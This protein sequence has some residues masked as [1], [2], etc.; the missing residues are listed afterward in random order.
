MTEQ[1]KDFEIISNSSSI[2][3]S[4]CGEAE[5][6]DEIII[7]TDINEEDAYSQNDH[8]FMF[9]LYR[10]NRQLLDKISEQEKQITTLLERNYYLANSNVFWLCCYFGSIVT[11]LVAL[12]H[13]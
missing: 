11:G 9:D 3:E 2:M 1:H 8:S 13:H 4:S 12:T 6:N 5:N 7:N 10:E